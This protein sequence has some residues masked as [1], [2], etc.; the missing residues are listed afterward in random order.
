MKMM[1]AFLFVVALFTGASFK[2]KPLKT[3][4]TVGFKL[5]AEA[6]EFKRRL[7]VCH[8]HLDLIYNDSAIIEK[9]NSELIED[10]S[11]LQEQL[12]EARASLSSCED[13]TARAY[14]KLIVTLEA[15]VPTSDEAIAKMR[16]HFDPQK[17]QGMYDHV[18]EDDNLRLCILSTPVCLRDYDTSK[19]R[20]NA[21]ANKHG[22]LQTVAVQVLE[23]NGAAPAQ[24]KANL[25]TLENCQGTSIEVFALAPCPQGIPTTNNRDALIKD[26]AEE[27][28]QEAA[29]TIAGTNGDSVATVSNEQNGTILVEEQDLHHEL[30]AVAVAGDGD[31]I[32]ATD[33]V[34][35]PSAAMMT[36]GVGFDGEHP[37]TGAGASASEESEELHSSSK[38]SDFVDTH[39]A[40]PP[41]MT[42]AAS[43]STVLSRGAE[44]RDYRTKKCD[45]QPISWEN[46]FDGVSDEAERILIIGD[47]QD[48]VI[49]G[50]TPC[51][52]AHHQGID[53]YKRLVNIC[54]DDRKR[55]ED[56]R[57]ADRKHCEDSREADRQHWEM[58]QKKDRDH[59]EAQRATL[60]NEHQAQLERE[61]SAKSEECEKC[62][63]ALPLCQKKE[64]QRYAANDLLQG[65]I[66]EERGQFETRLDGAAKQ[67]KADVEDLKLAV[68]RVHSESQQN[69]SILVH[70]L[71]NMTTDYE[72]AKQNASKWE[73]H[74]TKLQS[75]LTDSQNYH[76]TCLE[77]VRNERQNVQDCKA[78]NELLNKR[79]QQLEREALNRNNVNEALRNENEAL[80]KKVAKF[81]EQQEH[82]NEVMARNI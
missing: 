30:V 77:D 55:C 49:E 11:G 67:N 48:A 27:E 1:F 39:T 66:N 70:K 62:L 50:G 52:V 12:N 65:K 44:V 2:V 73:C 18:V 54:A 35:A 69:S 42:M 29:S 45:L 82:L 33:I 64:A 60:I 56:S 51:L 79:I 4:A 75:S 81:Q 15:P 5:K 71:G 59:Y 17:C 72:N 32:V 38:A 28:K 61:Q 20:F 14:G 47:C 46:K 21:S 37:E 13:R 76:E 68:A 36:Y 16:I 57:E 34:D 26:A 41:S 40:A 3:V 63:V 10:N 6:T 7:H 9:E 24:V 58:A 8:K 53:A 25:E 43:E 31:G 78:E 74:A 22:H 19:A 23:V 80:N